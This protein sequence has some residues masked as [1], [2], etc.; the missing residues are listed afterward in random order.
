MLKQQANLS[1]DDVEKL[2]KMSKEERKAWG[3]NSG[4]SRW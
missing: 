1:M 4:K 2:K 3:E